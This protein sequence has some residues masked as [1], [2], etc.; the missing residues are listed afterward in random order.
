MGIGIEGLYNSAENFGR[1]ED[2]AATDSIEVLFELALL[3]EGSEITDPVRLNQLTL[4]MLQKV[5]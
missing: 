2:A 4:A 1:A 3:A 5:L